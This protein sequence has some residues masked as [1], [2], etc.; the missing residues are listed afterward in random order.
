MSAML[1]CLILAGGLGT[2]LRPV[3]GDEVPK[4]LAP[5]DGEPFLCWMLKGL[6][7]QGVTEVVL[8]LGYGSGRIKDLLRTRDFGMAISVI[9]EDEPLGTG[10][11]IVHAIRA[12]GAADMIVMNGD[13]LS[14]LD[15]R[16]LAAFYRETCPDLVLAA[17]PMHDASRY[18]TLDFDMKSRRLSAFREKRHGHGYIN[19]GTYV[20]NVQKLLGFDFPEKF[21]FE[22]AFLSERV[23]EL[24]IRVFPEVTEFIDIG[25][26]ADYARAQAVIPLMLEAGVSEA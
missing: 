12:H 13:T 5:I 4:A 19:A 21:S 15:L 9:E 25:V 20:V 24:D 14:N 23:A 26:P 1:P 8:S 6:L 2:R 17:T 3:L 16:K 11:A 10:G 22:Q 7:Q 18:G